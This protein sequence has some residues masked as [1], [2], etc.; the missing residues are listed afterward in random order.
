ME[1]EYPCPCLIL[2]LSVRE[3]HRLQLHGHIIGEI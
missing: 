1:S 2:Q 3:E